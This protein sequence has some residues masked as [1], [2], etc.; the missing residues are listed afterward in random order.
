[1]RLSL[2][3][4]QLLA[5]IIASSAQS[6]AAQE[7]TAT[8]EQLE[9]FEAK[10]RPVLVQ[11]CYE[12]H[13]SDSKNVKGGLLLDTRAATLKGG[14]SGPAVVAK[15]VEDSLLISALK[16]ESLEMPPKRKLPDAV[17]AD[18]VAWVEAGA[19]D[20]RAGE[21]VMANKIDFAEAR[22]FWSFKPIVA[23]ELPKVQQTD[24]PRNDIDLFVLAKL[25]HLGLQPVSQAGKLELIRR[26]T[27]DLIGL[28]PTLD[29]VREFVQDE[30]ENAFEKVVDRLLASKTLR[31]TMGGDTG[32][33]LRV[34][35]KIKLTHFRSH[36]I[37]TAIAIVTGWYPRS[38]RICRTSN[39]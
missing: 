31:R 21:S 37:A 17:I 13:S 3:V 19:A 32:W 16:H 22:T 12:C 5:L 33:T 20:P 14:D 4:G 18:F 36:P 11:H 25:E 34:T 10:I 23:P 28:P 9:F 38:T 26:A 29:E 39:L 1:M 27:F 24:W 8:A 2:F 15:N 6:N 7:L 30:S 35:P